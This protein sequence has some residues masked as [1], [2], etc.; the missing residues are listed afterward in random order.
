MYLSWPSHHL[1]TIS[2][3]ALPLHAK[4]LKRVAIY[5]L[6]N[7]F[8]F[9]HSFLNLL[10]FH[11]S[12]PSLWE[13]L[14]KMTAKLVNGNVMVSFQSPFYLIDLHNLPFLPSWNIFFTWLLR[15]TISKFSSYFPTSSLAI[16]F[17][18]LQSLK[19]GISEDSSKLFFSPLVISTSLTPLNT[20]TNLLTVLNLNFQPRLYFKFQTHISH[21]LLGTFSLECFIGI[22]SLTC[23]KTNSSSF[24]QTHSS[25]NL[26]YLR[27]RQRPPPAVL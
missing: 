25:C 27:K 2:F 15:T 3:S 4:Y 6:Y 1:T 11:P 19:V 8:L 13:L 21:C 10:H 5:Y 20:T 23:P 9:S 12:P 26:Q 24:P 18:F 16:P 22:S 7:Q 17:Q 14:L